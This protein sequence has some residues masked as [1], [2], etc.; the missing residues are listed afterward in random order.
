MNNINE[1][2]RDDSDEEIGEAW[3][4]FNTIELEM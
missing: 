3:N 4:I 2:A 1:N